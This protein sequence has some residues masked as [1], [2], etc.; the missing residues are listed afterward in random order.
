MTTATST[1]T[2]YVIGK[3][4]A[5]G[6]K[7]RSRVVISDAPVKRGVFTY[8]DWQI[9]A[10]EPYRMVHSQLGKGSH[11]HGRAHAKPS[12]YLRV[13]RDAY[14]MAWFG[15]VDA[16]GWICRDHDQFMTTVVVEGVVNESKPCSPAC[17]AATNAECDCACGGE[18][19]GSNYGKLEGV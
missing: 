6:C 11:R 5:K 17:R 7:N 19:H 16:A 12:A 18:G 2:V 4:T 3:C 1:T 10:T 14:S 8:T 13:N 9:P 15:A